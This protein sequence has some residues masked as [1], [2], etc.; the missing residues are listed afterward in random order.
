MAEIGGSPVKGAP[1][2]AH[3]KKKIKEKHVVSSIIML[4]SWQSYYI[5]PT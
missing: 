4:Y 3:T 2:H 5:S 1:I